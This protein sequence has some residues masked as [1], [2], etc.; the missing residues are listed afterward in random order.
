MPRKRNPVPKYLHHKPTG[1]SFIWVYDA[2]TGKRRPVYL[3]AYDSR[4]SKKRYGEFAEKIERG[5]LP[6]APPHPLSLATPP[7]AGEQI[8]VAILAVAFLQHCAAYYRR[9]DGRPLQE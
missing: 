3:G 5:N 6:P 9:A 2:I 4:D 7:A 1:Q 8:T